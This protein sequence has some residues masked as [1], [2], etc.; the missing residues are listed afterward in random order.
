MEEV[1]WFYFDTYCDVDLI[2]EGEVG[3]GKNAEMK[4][5]DDDYDGMDVID[6]DEAA[7]ILW[8]QQ[9]DYEKDNK[10]DTLA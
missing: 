8:L 9:N 7:A 1:W 10:S 2:V 3:G 6:I 4:P 5:A